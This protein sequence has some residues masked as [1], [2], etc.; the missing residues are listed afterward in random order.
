MPAEYRHVSQLTIAEAR[1]TDTARLPA[2]YTSNQR[3][4]GPDPAECGAKAIVAFDWH[5][6]DECYCEWVD[7]IDRDCWR[8]PSRRCPASLEM[9]PTSVSSCFKDAM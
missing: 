5:G 6:E 8:H 9:H 1:S 2:R 4:R 7:P 3:G